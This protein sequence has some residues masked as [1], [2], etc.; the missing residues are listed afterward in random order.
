MVKVQG[1]PR[2]LEAVSRIEAANMDVVS[3]ITAVDALVA[4]GEGDLGRVLYK[5]WLL[6][7]PNH[8]MRHIIAFNCGSSLLQQGD[9]AGARKYLD[10]AIEA[11]PEFYQAR[12]N[13]ASSYE[14]SGEAEAAIAEWQQ[15]VDRLA[16][17]SQLNISLKIQAFK[18]IARVKRSTE[19]AETV[20]RQAIELD[21]AQPDLVQHW[22]NRRQGRCVWPLLQPVGNLSVRAILE[23]MAP[24]SMAAFSDDPLLQLAVARAYTSQMQGAVAG[25]MVLG[26]WLAPEARPEKLKVAYLSSD[27]CHHAVGYLMSDVFENHDRSRYEITVFNIG[28]RN[29]DAIQKRIMGRVDHWFDIRGVPDKTAAQQIIAQGID[30][31]IDMN[32]HT[33]YQ[34]TALLAMKPAPII[35]N[36]LG[37]PG[38]MGSSDHH[39][40]IADDFLIPS[41]FESYYSEKVLRLPCYQPNGKLYPVPAL[42][43]TRTELGLPET[44]VVFCCFNGSV[45]ITEPVFAR[46]CVILASVPGSVI[47]LRGSPEDD[48]ALRLRAEAARRGIAPERLVFLPFRSNTEYLGCHRHADLFLDTF[49]YGAHTTAS[50]A[51]RM[52]VPIVTLAGLS[53]ASRVCGS[54]SR[55][56]GL[57]DLIC[58]TPEEYVARAIELGN[59]P[60]ALAQMKQKLAAS[61]PG[62][63]LFNASKLVRH[64]EGLFETMWGDYAGGTLHRPDTSWLSF[65]HCIPPDATQ[66][67][68]NL[69][70]YAQ[71]ERRRRLTAE[72]F[73]D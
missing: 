67:N 4:S 34:R 24:L 46:W 60:E 36:W 65:D 51:L 21:P 31:L 29:D 39:Y 32:G 71:Y 38:T 48:F 15:I 13:L 59:N 8:S 17:V 55:A 47:W 30:I 33:N 3:L 68:S 66:V 2:F 37:Y 40:I 72:F 1:S 53:F 25:P 52:G 12:L 5:F 54:L 70:P 11:N 35:A 10:Q 42:Q 19:V 73:R 28:E 69:V 57:S 41:G 56:A 6:E 58:I 63:D 43:A 14:R 16:P 26:T 7:N 62:C 50:D 20:L 23:R 18:N 61:L 27:F 64:L 9:I 49:P 44:G 45:K 22:V